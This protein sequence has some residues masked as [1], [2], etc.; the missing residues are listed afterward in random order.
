[1]TLQVFISYKSEYREFAR[2]VKSELNQWGFDTW[3]DV[4]NIQPGD[5]FRHKIQAGLD[6]SDVL[7]MVLTEEAQLSREVMSEV[8]YFLDVAK[9]PVVP[10]RHRE[11]KPLYIFVSI[12]YIDFVTDQANGFVQLKQRLNELAESTLEAVI[13]LP[14][15]PEPMREESLQSEVTILDDFI[16]E[17]SEQK[18]EILEDGLFNAPASSPVDAPMPQPAPPPPQPIIQ[19][20]ASPITS[21]PATPILEPSRQQEYMPQPAGVG[22]KGSS[23]LLWPVA[24]V[25]SL[26]VIVGAVVLFSVQANVSIT[27]Q[28][29]GIN[30]LVWVGVL[31][32]A[33]VI[34]VF[35]W[36]RF[37]QSKSRSLSPSPTEDAKNR[38]MMLQN[39]E[40]F[41]L[42]GVLDPALEA[43]T[44]EM[45]LSSA[46]GAVL[47]HKD[48]GDYEL[49][50]NANILDVFNDLNRELLILGAPGGGKTV[51]LLQLAKELIEQA[52]N[53]TP[54]SPPRIQG[55]E[56]PIP[57]VFNLSSWAAE[58]KPLADWLVDELRQKYQV[59][60]KVATAWVEGEKLL[61]LL[62]GLDEVAEQ[63]RNACVDAINAFRQ[64]YRTVDLAICSRV[65]DYDALTSKLD[66]RGAIVLEPL[67]QQVIE[68]YLNRPELE[69]LLQVI[70]NDE[71]LQ[72]MAQVPFLLNAMAYAYKGSTLTNLEFPTSDNA[73]KARR[74]HLFDRW[75][76]KRLQAKPNVAYMPIKAQKWLGWLAEK[77]AS[78]KNSVFY[79]E[80]LSITEVN[81]E[82]NNLLYFIGKASLILILSVLNVL[83]IYVVAPLFNFTLPTSYLINFIFIPSLVVFSLLI[84]IPSTTI[85][86]LRWS[87][88]G[89]IAT[90]VLYI[91]FIIA[92]PLIIWNKYFRKEN[93]DEKF[94]LKW[95]FV[96]FSIPFVICLLTAYTIAKST[97]PVIGIIIG[98]PLG[99]IIFLIGGTIVGGMF[100]GIGYKKELGRMYPNSGIFTSLRIAILSGSILYIPL[101]IFSIVISHSKDIDLRSIVLLLWIFPLGFATLLGGNSVLKHFIIRLLSW[102]SGIAPWNYARFLGYCASVGIMRKVGG[103]YIFAHRYVMEYFADLEVK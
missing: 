52:R 40:D 38:A 31:V 17:K 73:V 26:V 16:E 10:L 78:F 1:M 25:A 33:G 11:C 48:Y 30:P 95:A 79:I 70:E 15:E 77:M 29:Q 57:V 19:P 41:W 53:P 32:I 61:L 74:T 97:S 68:R 9:K 22:R 45:G 92:P 82:F 62:D 46:P 39:V 42:K 63:Y 21:A 72:D 89:G 54:Q 49:P 96:V 101:T 103:G 84:L 69:S 28:P 51:L 99:L 94:P 65:L 71:E 36:R 93:R 4:D 80:D 44:F 12:Q 37:G 27:Q 47:R 83:I 66:V 55:G 24:A 81:N 98:F 60:K 7:L 2:A 85:E 35:G 23:P 3:L 34:G 86:T 56:A 75:V 87:F 90:A 6:S 67:S 13:N 18:K 58:R 76:E 100:G 5:Y 64:T 50:A 88:S 102:Y 59:P 20:P 91:A 8:D 43:G 14:A